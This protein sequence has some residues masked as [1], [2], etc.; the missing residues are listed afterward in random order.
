MQI[1]FTPIGVIHSPFKELV[2]MPI[3]PAGA[4][5]ISGTIELEPQY[6]PALQD[7]DGFSHIYVLYYFHTIE[8]LETESDPLPGQT[9]TRFIFNARAAPPQ[10]DR[11]VCFQNRENSGYRIEVC[12]VD[13]LDGTPLLDIK[14]YVPQFDNADNIRIGWIT[15]NIPQVKQVRTDRRFSG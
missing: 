1:T 11:A 7:L 4:E 13:V 8:R 5:D 6:V 14:P 10:P 2:D 15:E 9:G 3:Q 12:H